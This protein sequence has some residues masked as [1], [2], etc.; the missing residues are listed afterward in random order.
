[1]QK[2]TYTYMYAPIYLHIYMLHTYTM[3]YGDTI[4]PSCI[5][6]I[7]PRYFHHETEG[8]MMSLTF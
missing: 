7:A 5:G 8:F 1:M 3:A 6:I 4:A 2:H